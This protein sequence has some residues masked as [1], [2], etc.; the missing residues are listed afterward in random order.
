MST[1]QGQ[2][3]HLHSNCRKEYTFMMCVNQSLLFSLRSTGTSL[4]A[5]SGARVGKGWGGIVDTKQI[6][7]IGPQSSVKSLN[8]TEL[9]GR[10]WIR[11]GKSN[12]TGDGGAK[13]FRGWSLQ[14]RMNLSEDTCMLQINFTFLPPCSVGSH[15]CSALLS[16]AA[17]SQPGD[18]VQLSSL[19][20]I[21]AIFWDHL[22]LVL[23]RVR[24][25]FSHCGI[26]EKKTPQTEYVL[27]F[28]QCEQYKIVK[29]A[30]EEVFFFFLVFLTADS[31]TEISFQNLA[32]ASTSLL[33]LSG[34][35]EVG[36]ALSKHPVSCQHSAT[37]VVSG[38]SGE[39]L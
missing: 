30:E 1:N 33:A 22:P 2:M 34:D 5:V 11:S 4:T 10:T 20:R 24:S 19:F 25:N 17:A 8:G 39:G 3:C 23:V 29:S 26:R 14:R 27:C 18:T 12:M 36:C 28:L 35:P 31:E 7:L 15:F 9:T 38:E 6:N 13:I 37:G 16:F 32:N 21:T